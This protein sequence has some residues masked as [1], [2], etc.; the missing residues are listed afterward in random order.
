MQAR[1][2]DRTRV[3][4]SQGSGPTT[5]IGKRVLVTGGASGIGAAIAHRFCTDGHTVAI[6]DTRAIDA[7]EAANS[8][9]LLGD[10]SDVEQVD[11]AFARLDSEWDGGIDIVVN[12]A[13]ISVREPF[14]QASLD[15]WNR[16]L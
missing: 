1:Q 6:L 4:S 10:V 13:G 2:D 7:T 15:S 8:I 12:N 14:L 3:M 5:A 9:R 11:A 16:V